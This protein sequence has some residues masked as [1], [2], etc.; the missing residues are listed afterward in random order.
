MSVRCLL[1]TIFFNLF[2]T[3][4]SIEFCIGD[5]C[6][7]KRNTPRKNTLLDLFLE[8][9]DI[10]FQN[11]RSMCNEIFLERITMV[12]YVVGSVTIMVLL[13]LLIKGRHRTLENQN[14]PTTSQSTSSAQCT[15]PMAT[16]VKVSN[17]VRFESDESA[18]LRTHNRAAM[19][20]P[21]EFKETTNL[22]AW[23]TVL[24]TYLEKCCETKDC[25]DVAISHINIACLNDL[26]SKEDM[27]EES[28]N[29]QQL[30]IF[31]NK[32][33]GNKNLNQKFNI[34]DFANMKQ[35]A[36]QSIREYGDTLK[37]TAQIVFSSMSLKMIEDH[38]VSAFS[39]G[40]FDDELK[41]YAKK[42]TLQAENK[43][44]LL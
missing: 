18:S 4:T 31:L 42:K 20:Q 14:K 5:Y 33:Y 15:S 29:F 7:W 17:T 37:R 23:L 28:D 16:G 1:L 24:Q 43:N 30:K 11:T 34:I 27:R 3:V 44:E 12:V 22:A 8:I 25:F 10:V 26:P 38:L 21:S 19:K 6:V 9:L 36:R 40:L 41:A 35:A 2:L 39:K 13:F 32:K